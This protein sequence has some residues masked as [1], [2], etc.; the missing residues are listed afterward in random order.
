MASGCVVG[1]SKGGTVIINLAASN[2]FSKVKPLCI[3]I[4]REAKDLDVYIY[5]INIQ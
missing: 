2:F 4:L 5:I 1:S 3:V